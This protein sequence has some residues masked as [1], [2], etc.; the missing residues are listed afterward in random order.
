M[1]DFANF[2]LRSKTDNAEKD[3]KNIVVFSKWYLRIPKLYCHLRAIS[4]R[5][6]FCERVINYQFSKKLKLLRY[7]KFNY[8]ILTLSI[9][10]GLNYLLIGE[11]NKW[12]FKNEWLNGEDKD[13][14]NTILNYRFSQKLILMILL[15]I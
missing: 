12:D 5:F 14:S 11:S 7:G 8:V 10:G 2:Q 1:I 4:I 3:K 15:K 13:C 9:H 6:V